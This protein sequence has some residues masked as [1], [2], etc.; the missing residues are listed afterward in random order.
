MFV[1]HKAKKE[2]HVVKIFLFQSFKSYGQPFQSFKSY[3]QRMQN[4]LGSNTGHWHLNE[5]T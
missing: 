4:H 2:K 3:G 5:N 1:W